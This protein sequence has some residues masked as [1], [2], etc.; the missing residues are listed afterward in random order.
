MSAGSTTY[1][2]A[3]EERPMFPGSPYSPQ[4]TLG[5]RL[6]YAGMAIL[7][8]V[9]ASFGNALV[10]VNAP[11]LA[12]AVGLYA[13]Q[14]AWLPAIYVA[15]NATA[16]LS[17][18][19]ARARFGI[20][21]V[22]AVLLVAYALAAALQ[23]AWPTFAAAMLT[24]AASGMAA[25]GLA[26]LTVYG[27]LQA[28]PARLRPLALIFGISL[29]QVGPALA[30]IVP[31]ELVVADHARGLHLM[32]LGVALAALAATTAVRLPPSDRGPAFE[33]LDLLTIG[34]TIPGMLLLCGVLSLGRLLW[35]TDTPWLGWALAAAVPLLL[36]AAM[37][38]HYR[39]R[40]L[41]QTRWI[42]TLDMARFAAVAVLVRV[43]LAEQTYGSVGLLT[44]GGLNND[45]LRTLFAIVAAAMVLGM[46]VAALTL[47]ERRLP[48]QVLAAAAIIG[49]AAWLDSHANNLTR[50]GQLYLSQAMIGFGTTLFIGPG[51]VYGFLR[52]MSRGGDHLVT[53]VVLF[54]VTQNL[55]GLAGSA[56]LGTYQTIAARAH[57][58]ALSE[59]LNAFDPQ[60]AARIQAG[61]SSLS[62][63]VV[64]PLARGA[65]GGGL[66]GQAMG[67]E[68]NILAFNDT[69]RFVAVL[70]L[71]TVVYLAYIIVFNTIR[72]R[73]A[74]AAE[75]AA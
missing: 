68:A 16:N 70:A 37:I 61:A 34:L 55:G 3:P 71:L 59:R 45:Q 62:G 52:M 43:A 29:T 56:L 65:Q 47:S 32:E 36:A 6:A 13:A 46:V 22:T 39:A 44:S 75:P 64:D 23:L 66:L 50:P 18:V 35:W 17:L 11:S 38:E 24:R 31:V 63:A 10:T 27:F 72:R 12:G 49:V 9:T 21:Q 19:K 7:T 60:V 42:G 69:F 5:R 2:F 58:G 30:R 15:F 26:T 41:L 4:H 14:L 28:F 53:F 48:Y 73:R 33:R 1:E 74:A 67:R 8:G 57:A 25:A 40:P 51:M 20:P 54:S